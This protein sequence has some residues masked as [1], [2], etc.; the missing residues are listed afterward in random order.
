MTPDDRPDDQRHPPPD[1]VDGSEAGRTPPGSATTSPPIRKPKLAT[2]DR[3]FCPGTLDANIDLRLCGW[4]YGITADMYQDTATAP[5]SAARQTPSAAGTCSR[6]SR[7]TACTATA[8]STM[9]TPG[10]SATTA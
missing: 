7:T 4:A 1:R 8:T 5:N 2:N 10:T 6:S 9:T 3:P